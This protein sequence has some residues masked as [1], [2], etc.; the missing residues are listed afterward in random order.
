MTE[1]QNNVV[2]YEE[3]MRMNQQSWDTLLLM[4]DVIPRINGSGKV[5]LKLA[6]Y[7][8]VMNN[9]KMLQKTL[10]EITRLRT[11][12]SC[13]ENVGELLAL[14]NDETLN[15]MKELTK[16]TQEGTEENH[17]AYQVL[18]TDQRNKYR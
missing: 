16:A 14:P 10:L 1:Q 15:I 3:I 12:L 18:V 4:T 5:T 6:E 17:W 13:I 7:E 2:T 9:V 11:A 8:K